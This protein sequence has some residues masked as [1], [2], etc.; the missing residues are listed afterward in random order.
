MGFTFKVMGYEGGQK[1]GAILT[2]HRWARLS[3]VSQ[4]HRW[5]AGWGEETRGKGT[6][7]SERDSSS[8][9]PSPCRKHN[10]TELFSTTL[11]LIY[12]F[13]GFRIWL[14]SWYSFKESPVLWFF[15]IAPTVPGER[16]GVRTHLLFLPSSHSSLVL[17]VVAHRMSLHTT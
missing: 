1:W 13:L 2:R 3:G 17:V 12:F 6:L 7:R 15:A 5:S 11:K 14:Y 9:I 16:D 8:L 10:K 4:K